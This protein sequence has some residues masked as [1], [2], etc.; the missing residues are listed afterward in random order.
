M[1]RLSFWICVFCSDGLPEDGTL[2]SKHVGV[3]TY[4]YVLHD[5]NCIVFIKCMFVNIL[6]TIY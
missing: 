3:N 4:N 1:S 2:L 6:S 5:L